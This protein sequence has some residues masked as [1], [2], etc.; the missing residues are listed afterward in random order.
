[1]SKV[2]GLSEAT[3]EG[4]VIALFAGILAC[5][6]HWTVVKAFVAEPGLGPVATG[7]KAVHSAMATGFVSK[8]GNPAIDQLFSRGV[9]SLLTPSGLSSARS[10][11]PRSWNT[12]A[13]SPG[14]C[15]RWSRTPRVAAA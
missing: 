12:P 1:M 2:M 13:S 15:S 7:I 14:S 3:A 9:S 11:S 5:F 10:R 8:T 6:T 4:A